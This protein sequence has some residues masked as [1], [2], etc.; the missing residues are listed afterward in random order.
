MA[1]DNRKFY[2]YLDDFNEITIIIPNRHYR[3]KTKY[4]LLGNDEV[5]DLDIKERI[6]IGN[7]T[8][9]VCVFDAYIELRMIYHVV[10]DK[11]EKSELY[12]GKIVR[13]ELFDNIYYYKKDDLGATY[14][15]TATKF[16]IWTPVAK[17]VHL[18]L[19]YKD[20]T[21]ETRAMFYTNAGVWRLVVKG[22]LEGV[23]YRYHVYVNGQEQ[24]VGDPYGI[25]STANG[26]Y[27]YVI[28]KEKLYVINHESPFKGSYLDSVIYEMNARDFS[29]DENVPFTHRGKYLGV[30]EKKL[31]TPGGNPAG[32][33]YLKYLGITHVQIM[34]LIDFGGVDENNPDFLYNWGYNPEQYF[35]PEGWYATEPDDPYKRIDELKMMVDGLHENGISVIMDVVYNHVYEASQFSLEKLVPGY[36]FNV[37]REGIMTNYS[38]CKNDLATYRKMTRKLIIDSVLYW[39]KEFKIDGFRFDLMGIIDFETMNEL[40]QELHE[41]SDHLIVYGEGWR[42]HASNLADRMAHM[43]NKNVLYT[44]GFFNDVFRDTIKG[45]TFE[46][47]EKG[48]ATG[49]PQE[50][51]LVAELM[52]GSARNR[53]LFKYTSQSI[54]YVECHD[55]MT[56][57]DK[58]MLMSKNEKLAK[59]QQ[60]L[61]T[62]MVILAQGVPFIHMGQEFFRT[63]MNEDNSY[64]SGDI[65]NKINWEAVDENLKYINFI[66]ELIKF[67]K[68]NPCLRLRFHSELIA[69]SETTVL[70]SKT[71]LIHYHRK[72]NLI[73][74]FKP[75]D[76]RENISVP[77]DYELV[78][79]SASELE[80]IGN[81]VYQIRELGTY[82]F[83]KKGM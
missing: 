48:Y 1:Q 83:K 62:A 22:D 38:G 59:R 14:Q 66:R 41:L 46:P 37:D 71:L 23:R 25:A 33:D 4:R 39:A 8:K 18:C 76:H 49:N 40:R 56:F 82:L 29:M 81:G 5:I 36:A 65:I 54:N 19:I 72:G 69:E 51:P 30:I 2:C 42:L 31:K 7:E 78:L 80:E 20:G 16:K 26:D 63:K 17:Y 75:L 67:R 10:S 79:T 6:P 45:K 55:N 13:T 58:A 74:V 34:P 61:A 27:N 21:S 9:L 32:L 53:Y 60:L 73:L 11:E 68:D 28:D 12:T 44:I 15:K 35:V 24:I 50:A 57:H 77:A 70:A 52:L 3:E 43:R 64:K 47:L